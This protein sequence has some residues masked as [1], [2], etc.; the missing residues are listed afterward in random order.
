MSLCL[1]CMVS[2]AFLGRREG[3]SGAGEGGK[4]GARNVIGRKSRAEARKGKKGS[5]APASLRPAQG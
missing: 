1:L 2:L 3:E 4:S 5:L